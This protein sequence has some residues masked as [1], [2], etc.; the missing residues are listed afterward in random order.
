MKLKEIAEKLGLELRGNGEVDING[1]SS[2]ED[3]REGEIAPFYRKIYERVAL[4]SKASAFL[5]GPDTLIEGRNLLVSP[6]PRADLIRL[7]RLFHPERPPRR[8]ISPTAIIHPTVQLGRDV[9]IGDFVKIGENSVLGDGVEIHAG[10]VI[11]PDVK[12]GPYTRIY[13]NV[14]IREG[15]EIGEKC[16]IHPG[17]VIGCDGFGFEAGEKIPQVGRVIIGSEVEIGANT[18]IDRAAL[19][20][21]RIENRVKIGNLCLIAH[22][23]KIG[24]GSMLAGMIAIGGSARIG[25]GV[26]CGGMVGIR[27]NLEVGDGAMIAAKTCVFRP[28]APGEVVGG[29]PNTALTRWKRAMA[30][31]YRLGKKGKDKK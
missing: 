3:A 20:A 26:I 30:W 29:C 22:G 5:V 12:I 23:T 4:S 7:I 31:L 11:Y 9:Y 28:V 13:S 24:E 8:G 17:V 16:I 25:K 2:L 1:V 15:T 19:G 27:D 21:T 10:S 18:V 6:R 14:V